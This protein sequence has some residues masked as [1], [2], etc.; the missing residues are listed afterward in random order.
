MK[1]RFFPL[2]IG[3]CVLGAPT[4]CNQS[5]VGHP[6]GAHLL[7]SLQGSVDARYEGTGTFNFGKVSLSDDTPV[8]YI[9]SIGGGLS[10]GQSFNFVSRRRSSPPVG[11]YPVGLVDIRQQPGAQ[12]FT[13]S[14]HRVYSPQA[15]ATRLAEAYAAHAGEVT[16]TL[17]SADRI[18]GT[19]RLG[20]FRY[21]A[22]EDGT[23]NPPVGPCTPPR[24][25]IT[26]APTIDVSGS[27]VLTRSSN[28]VRAD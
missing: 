16:I 2:V 4:A 13:A 21:C 18:E 14:F 3:A 8:F 11:S 9:N 15:G 10:E 1:A 28:I 22:R 5:P 25:P 24:E 12:G 7:A 19:F 6:D 17:S 23:S 26:D 27:F 20:G